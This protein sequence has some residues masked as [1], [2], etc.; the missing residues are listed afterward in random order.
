MHARSGRAK[1]SDEIKSFLQFP[2]IFFPPFSKIGKCFPNDRPYRD[3]FRDET[4]DI[5]DIIVACISFFYN[6]LKEKNY[7]FQ[8][9]SHVKYQNILLDSCKIQRNK[10]TSYLKLLTSSDLMT[11]C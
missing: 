7:V 4:T 1:Q 8:T 9:T 10:F 11:N 2:V 6:F 5:E 3:D